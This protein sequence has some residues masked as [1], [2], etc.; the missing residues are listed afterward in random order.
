MKKIYTSFILFVATGMFAGYIPFAPGTFGSMIGAVIY[1]AA[2][3]YLHIYQL[4]ILLIGMYLI[5]TFAADK[6][7]KIL[8][9]QDS[10]KIVIDEIVGMYVTMFFIPASFANILIGFICFRALDI[11]KPYP[12]SYLDTH[13]HGGT[14]IMLDDVAAGIPANIL[15][16]IVIFLLAIV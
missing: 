5:G 6:A 16:R 2:S 12:I 15:T 4:V 7:E 3:K 13:V 14:G 8:H 9:E 10:G 1:Y 11:I